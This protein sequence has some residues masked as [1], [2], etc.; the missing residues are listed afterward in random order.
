MYKHLGIALLACCLLLTA[1]PVRAADADNKEYAIKAAFIYNFLKFVRWP[2][3]LAT[4]KLPGINICI[5]GDNP[6]TGAA[7]DVFKRASNAILKLTIVNYPEWSKPLD[8]CHVV[9][10]SQ[11]E[12]GVV[13]EILTNL[14][15]KPIL[16]VSEIDHFIQKGGHIGF[17]LKD[18][19]VK[20]LINQKAADV[21]GLYISADLMEVAIEVIRK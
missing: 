19:K 5:L 17:A 14:R 8:S 15:K 10:I 3:A 4:D 12:A 1:A 21:A 7:G 13:D 2:G 16:T 11:S 20:L 9:F 18:N 6:F